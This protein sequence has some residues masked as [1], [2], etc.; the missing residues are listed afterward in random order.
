MLQRKIPP[1][2]ATSHG[3]LHCIFT[4]VP[5]WADVPNEFCWLF[6]NPTLLDKVRASWNLSTLFFYTP[7]ASFMAR[8]PKHNTE[9]EKHVATSHVDVV[10]FFVNGQE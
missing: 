10:W 6:R 4:V 8:L 9:T 1:A 3:I 5:P 2:S 7:L